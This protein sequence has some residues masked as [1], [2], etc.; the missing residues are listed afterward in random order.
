MEISNKLLIQAYNALTGI[1]EN[2][3]MNLVSEIR[4]CN[5]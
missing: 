3:L 1:E 5:L 4:N 2:N